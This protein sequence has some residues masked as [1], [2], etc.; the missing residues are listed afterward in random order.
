M[1][2]EGESNELLEAALSYAARGWHV[3]PVYWIEDGKCSCNDREAC[4]QAGKHP[5]VMRGFHE[6]TTDADRITSWWKRWP[7]ANIGIAT[8]ASGLL[9]VD[10]DR[11]G[12]SDGMVWLDGVR[13]FIPTKC[14]VKTGGGGEHLFFKA[15]AYACKGK[16]KDGV[17]LKGEGGYVVAPPSMHRS[18]VEYAWHD[19]GEPGEVSDWLADLVRSE[20]DSKSPPLELTSALNLPGSHPWKQSKLRELQSAISCIDPAD[21]ETWLQVGF[22]I[23]SEFPD[24]D[25]FALWD[26]WSRGTSRGNYN[27]REQRYAWSKF[28][29]GAGINVETVFQLA[30]S[31]GW[32]GYQESVELT[33]ELADALSGTSTREP[34]NAEGSYTRV[35]MPIEISMPMALPE[36]PSSPLPPSMAAFEFP[37]H[38]LRPPG[39]IGDIAEWMDSCAAHEV[40]L[41]SMAAALSTVAVT[42]GRNYSTSSGLRSNLQT[43]GVCPTGVGKE[44]GRRCASLLLEHAKLGHRLGGEEFTSPASLYNQLKACPTSLSL[45]D[46]Y[47]VILQAQNASKVAQESLISNAFTKLATAEIF[48]GIQYAEKDRVRI[49]QP[50]FVVYGTTTPS[51]F[52][53][54]MSTKQVD[55]G[56]LGRMV[57]FI[58][59]HGRKDR[60]WNMLPPEPPPDIVER[61]VELASGMHIPAGA[62]GAGSLLTAVDSGELAKKCYRVMCDYDAEFMRRELDKV[63][64]AQVNG[65]PLF[66]ALWARLTAKAEMLALTCALGDINGDPIIKGK[67]MEWGRDV[68]MWSTQ[69]LI[70]LLKD[71]MSESQAQSDT[72]FVLNAIKRLGGQT[73]QNLLTRT[74]QK[75]GSRRRADAIRELQEGG[76]IRIDK[77]ASRMTVYTLVPVVL[78]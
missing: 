26:E 56:F 27:E 25:G 44:N 57:V 24:G 39:L 17:D 30:Y 19:D 38:L 32:H 62:V 47:G 52:A 51:D 78:Q 60:R 1:S 21:R 49:L 18:G 77:G 40:R 76:Q 66:G 31:S 23:N 68:A 65:D 45:I 53:R 36:G 67:H 10:C 70:L 48:H 75:I 55:G 4:K 16:L 74:T 8:G 28:Q 15:P 20:R 41:L 9:V 35:E 54:A 11:H 72:Q 37:P 22:G 58:V 3:F 7:R 71:N 73:T 61:I 29:P 33:G 12:E 5:T 43:L 13:S 59:D 64:S 46:E 50:H 6:A 63:C 42:I 69:R 34:S 14:R 2:E